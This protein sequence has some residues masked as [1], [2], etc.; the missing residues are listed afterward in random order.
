MENMKFYDKKLKL[1]KMQKQ[2]SPKKGCSAF[3]IKDTEHEYSTYML[4]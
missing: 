1:L 3:T 4:M 2:Y